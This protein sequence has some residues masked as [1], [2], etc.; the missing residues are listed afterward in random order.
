MINEELTEWLK[1][2]KIAILLRKSEGDKGSTKLQLERI[3][4]DIIRLEDKT[5]LK[6]KPDDHNSHF[7]LAELYRQSGLI[8]KA[9]K[10]NTIAIRL[11]PD[12][13]EAH[14]NLGG[15]NILK[16]NY[17]NAKSHYDQAEKLG[18]KIEKVTRNQ[19]NSL[20]KN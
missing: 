12:F 5:G 1:G 2:K 17:K 16:K 7:N 6:I 3:K 15:L 10:E 14:F 13:V 19:L 9:I 11:R 8:D 20:K 18:L 4:K